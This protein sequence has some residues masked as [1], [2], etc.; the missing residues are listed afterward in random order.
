[1]IPNQ[2]FDAISDAEKRIHCAE[3]TLQRTE[4]MLAETI[5][6]R[7]RMRSLIEAVKIDPPAV[8]NVAG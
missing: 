2:N 5:A 8:K 3:L 1:M 6:M 4:V 7:N